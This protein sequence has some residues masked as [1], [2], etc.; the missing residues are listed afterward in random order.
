[1]TGRLVHPGLPGQPP[2]RASLPP[3]LAPWQ[4]LARAA[5]AAVGR[6]CAQEGAGLGA[7]GL[8]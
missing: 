5:V 8:R 3:S 6:S 7:W 4:Q 1:M 2:A